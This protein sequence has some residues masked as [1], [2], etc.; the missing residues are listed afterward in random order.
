MSV[1]KIP[2]VP[3]LSH[4]A[5]V[6]GEWVGILLRLV[7]ALT[8]E[9]VT[10][11][12]AIITRDDL[13]KLKGLL[14]QLVDFD[15]VVV[16]DTGSRDG[17]RAYVR[18]LGPP[19][20]LHEFPWRGRPDGRGPD[21]WGFAAA[22]NES[23]SHLRTKY[24]AWIDSDDTF[25]SVVNGQRVV[26]SAEAVAT[27]LRK[28]ATDSPNVDVW[29]LDYVYS[30]DEFG[31]ATAVLAQDRFLKL[32]VGWHWRYPVH[33]VLFPVRDPKSLATVTLQDVVLVHHP[34]E[35]VASVKRNVPMLQGWLRQL[36]KNGTDR[37]GE[38]ARARW[39]VGR[40]L[41]GR[42]RYVQAARWMLTQYL[43]KHPEL[44]ANEKYEGWMDVAKDLIE[45]GDK[46]GAHH[47]LLEC[48]GLCPRFG[49]AYVLL[50][51]LKLDAGERPGDVLKLVEIA[52]SCAHEDQGTH[53]RN[54]AYASF[55]GPL[56]GAICQLR[57]G[58]YRE[59]VMLA[60]RA[61]AV[62]PGD[63][64]AQKVIKAAADAS[65]SEI[66]T[67]GVGESRGPASATRN[68]ARPDPPF[69]VVSSGRCGST[70][71]SN[72][73][74]LN[75]SVL[76]LSE[77]LIVLTPGAFAGAPYPVYGSQ[78]WSLLSTPRKRM[79]F[80]IRHGIVF[81]EILYRPGPG[82]RFTAETGVPP[83]LLTA[84]PH[85]TDD[86]D[87]LFDEIREF[88]L[89]QG[90]LPIGQHYLRLFDWLRERFGRKLWVERSGSLLVHL[91]QL[92]ENFPDARFVHLYRDGRECA[93]SMSRHSAFRLSAITGE[94]ERSIGVDPFNTDEPGHTEAPPELQR[95]MPENFDRDAFWSRKIPVEL[96][97]AGWAAEETRGLDLLGMLSPGRVLHM[98]YENLVANPKVEVAKL[99]RFLGLD[100]FDDNYLER[101]AALVKI[102]PPAWPRLPDGERQRLDESCRVAM[103]ML[104]GS[105]AL[106]PALTT[107]P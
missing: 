74:Q 32:D 15:Q 67:I 61:L 97:G 56:L 2:P 53:E 102:K 50:A 49:E 64:W 14:A 59:A 13:G 66:E 31:N 7:G 96:F 36:E 41:R 42:A 94:L 10:I 6:H 70:L 60:S 38:L 11:G 93:I 98:R 69:F 87:A 62:R 90:A 46:L 85:L 37:P 88:V 82:R 72:M 19:F 23:F 28:L 101:A 75:P 84:L 1:R 106:E 30:T 81:E 80:M 8:T 33:E 52:E 83:I 17:T 89:A 107:A 63:E 71:V 40:S 45:A 78:F 48:I 16:V 54:P 22:R 77:L 39:L 95:F 99:M 103:G 55:K 25:A 58:H 57:I 100:D 21:D 92:I 29:L 79:T 68:G 27:G 47:A 35:T 34:H 76:S 20:E 5:D 91:D 86:P 3:V 26:A 51:D 24:A 4:E 104:Y 105:Q 65:S 44:T 9:P 73:L 18:E 43:G 12:A